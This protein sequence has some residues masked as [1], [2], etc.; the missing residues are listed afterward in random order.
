MGNEESVPAVPA[1]VVPVSNAAKP[2]KKQ[3][4]RDAANEVRTAGVGPAWPNGGESASFDRPF[5]CIPDPLAEPPAFRAA[6]KKLYPNALHHEEAAVAIKHVLR[7]HG[8]TAHGSICLVAQCR[9]EITKPF[10]TAID[11][12]WMGSFNISSL[13]GTVFTGRTGFGA[14]LH[15]APQDDHGLERYVVFCGPHIAIDKDGTVGK[16]MRRGR[17]SLSTACGALLA[18]EAELRTGR[19]DTADKPLDIEYSNLKRRLLSGLDFGKPAPNLAELTAVCQET[20][21]DDVRAILAQHPGIDHMC[22]AIV[23]GVLIHGPNAHYF[24]AGHIEVVKKSS[25]VEDCLHELTGLVREAYKPEMIRYLASKA[26]NANLLCVGCSEPI[27]T[28][29]ARERADLMQKVV[30]RPSAVQAEIRRASHE[31]LGAPPPATDRG[32]SLSKEQL[33]KE[34]GW[35]K[36]PRTVEEGGVVEDLSGHGGSAYSKE[37]RFSSFSQAEYDAGHRPKRIQGGCACT[38]M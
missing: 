13:A 10:C 33:G 24:A 16:V 4:P 1:Q 6:L 30:S 3:S 28:G 18:F 12:N 38:L 36:A 8:F 14:A 23:S 26:E 37:K 32:R 35:A 25:A 17:A 22:F 19:V 20:T 21:I 34:Q 7:Q 29:A 31:E 5:A 15:H 9:D 27:S 11:H 2:A